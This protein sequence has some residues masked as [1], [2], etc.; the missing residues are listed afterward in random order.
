MM[1]DFVGRMI[2]RP[3]T[4]GAM[5]KRIS[6]RGFL[7]NLSFF[8]RLM[9]II[10]VVSLTFTGISA[11]QIWSIHETILKERESKLRDM[12][13]SV[14]RMLQSY[15]EEVVAGKLELSVAQEA[16]KKSIR[17]MRWGDG[18]YYGVYGFD[19]MTLVHGNPKNEGA[20]RMA[21]QDS[22]GR[23]T[24]EDL[25]N[26]AKAGGGFVDF[27]VPRAAGGQEGLKREFSA[28]FL[29]WKWVVQAGVYTDDV[30]SVVYQQVG[31]ICA[32]VVLDLLLTIGVA[33]HLG[34]GITR[35]LLDLCSVM[36]DL[37]TGK[38]DV[39]IPYVE[40]TNEAGRIAR[41]LE[42]FRSGLIEKADLRRAQDELREET[43]RRSRAVLLNLTN[44]LESRLSLAIGTVTDAA[45]GMRS[46]ASV[47]SSNA[48]VASERSVDMTQAAD[49]ASC[50]VQTVAGATEQLS[51]SVSE[52]NRQ[53]SIST[54]IANKACENAKKSGEVIANL[55]AAASKIGQVVSLID[56][57]AGQTNLLALNATIE[58]ARAGEMG[59]GFSVV[60][61][62]VKTL[63][64]QTSQAT[65]EISTQ[66]AE[67]QAATKAVVGA[68][69]RISDT[70]SEMGQI[71][72]SIA[73][74]VNQQCAAT[75]EISRSV[76]EAAKI[77]T[78]LS[79]F[80]N[81]IS[82]QVRTTG[83]SASKVFESAGGLERSMGQLRGEVSQILSNLR[84][85]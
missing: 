42:V 43:E 37:K 11:A 10:F 20:N 3:N 73:A 33:I 62:E 85:G 2:D 24:V 45:S 59:K 35:P 76:N 65:G 49:Q 72:S 80:A 7:K 26:L 5:V 67:I 71:G 55:S 77:T 31:W 9:L 29:P 41:A 54:A 4:L 60:A 27:M 56:K 38:V 48:S 36:D 64:H 46:V 25:I 69:T 74:A 8:Q 75:Q 68:I 23:R 30:N 1:L 51:D 12:V 47:M 34:R 44:E 28:P 39:N 32:T 6:P 13:S 70:I 14:V 81:E 16:A 52:I 79:T 66:V 53:M 63:A 57:I 84:T 19:G 15:N 58:S 50:N 40:L 82:A 17:A 18:D 22:H 21:V 83:Q 78:D 61:S